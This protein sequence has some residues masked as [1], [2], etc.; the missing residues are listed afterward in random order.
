[1]DFESA[2][3][4]VAWSDFDETG[5]YPSSRPLLAHYTSISVLESMLKH[6]E[7]WLSHPLLM[8]DH[9]ELAWGMRQGREAFLTSAAL[10]SACRTQ[11]RFE[12]LVRYF[13]DLYAKYE[14]ED[15][16][17]L[18]V[19]CFSEH[20]AGDPD[21][22]LSM[23]RGYGSNGGGVA[24]VFDTSKLIPVDDSPFVLA[25]VKYDCDDGRINSL[26]GIVDSLAS[27]VDREDPTSADLWY[28]AAN[29]FER[30]KLFS[31]FTKHKGFQEEREWRL[32]YLRDRDQGRKYD[33]LIGYHI[34]SDQISP[35]M[36]VKFS[37]FGEDGHG[38]SFDSLVSSVIVGPRAS[39]FLSICAIERMLISLRKNVFIEKIVECSTPFR[40]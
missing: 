12:I 10:M 31:V 13:V 7:I 9:Q 8:N 27:L 3:F 17:D 11:D 24:V 22:L 21:G 23:W 39:S 6:E 14:A 29:Y 19:T 37:A 16:R 20:D 4:Q 35:K 30:L 33:S 18:Y 15:A 1:M 40:G 25:P 38:Y 2:C 28:V 34:Y 26:K 36:K 32:A 5:I